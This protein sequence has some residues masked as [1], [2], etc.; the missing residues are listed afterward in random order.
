MWSSNK[1]HGDSGRLVLENGD[2]FEGGWH[3]HK[4]NGANCSDSSATTRTSHE[5]GYENGKRSGQ[6]K[7]N[8]VN[9]SNYNGDWEGGKKNG[10]GTFE[11]AKSRIIYDGSWEEN[12]PT[13]SASRVAISFDDGSGKKGGGG[14]AAKGA[15]NG[16]L[17]EVIV[18]CSVGQVF[19]PAIIRC[20]NDCINADR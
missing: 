14:K 8:Y 15:A 4:L 6:G 9:G 18:P 3:L 17:P 7:I 12:V 1:R 13:G 16:A 2:V 19:P 11:C 5:G 10:F 20:A